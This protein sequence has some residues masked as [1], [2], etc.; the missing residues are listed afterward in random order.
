MA[1]SNPES[2]VADAQSES[3]VG[4]NLGLLEDAAKSIRRMEAN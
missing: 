4:S 3:T 2:F 1:P